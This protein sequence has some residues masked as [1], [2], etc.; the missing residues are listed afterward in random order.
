MKRRS[1]SGTSRWETPVNS[2]R[3]TQALRASR[4]RGTRRRKRR[5]RSREEPPG[6]R[7]LC[8]SACCVA[9]LLLGSRPTAAAIELYAARVD[10]SILGPRVVLFFPP[11][12]VF[13]SS[14]SFARPP[15]VCL[16]AVGLDDPRDACF[17]AITRSYSNEQGSPLFYDSCYNRVWIS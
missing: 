2:G 11:L 15:V 14:S 7:Q 9:W 16:S 17:D 10:P 12:M 1:A 8:R 4:I 13:A 3:L 5:R 6:A